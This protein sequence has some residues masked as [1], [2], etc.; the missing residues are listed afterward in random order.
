MVGAILCADER[1][2]SMV[3]DGGGGMSTV[4]LSTGTTDG[5]NY[6]YSTTVPHL[7]YGVSALLTTVLYNYYCTPLLL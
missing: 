3:V 2:I 7:Q 5:Y 1:E 6:C 4:S